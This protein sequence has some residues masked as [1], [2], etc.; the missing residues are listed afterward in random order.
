MALGVYYWF[1]DNN[2]AN[3]LKNTELI[4]Q[5][6]HR[7]LKNLQAQTLTIR[8]KIQ[9]RGWM[10]LANP[11]TNQAYPYYIFLN[12]KPVVWSDYH[13]VPEVDSLGQDFDF[14]YFEN[15]F[16]KFVIAHQSI[17]QEE[18]TLH[19]YVLLPLYKQYRIENQYL[20]SGFNP[21][22][23]HSSL[24]II[25]SQKLKNASE[26]VFPN[27]NFLF[28]FQLTDSQSIT[29]NLHL[30]WCL[31][32]VGL[33]CIAMGWQS[34]IWR[35]S[36][37][38]KQKKWLYLIV[39]T[40]IILL[41]RALT[42][43]FQF[44]YTLWP[45]ELFNPKWYRSF[46]FPSLGDILVN[47][48]II[49]GL[50][51]FF[52]FENPRLRSIKILHQ[53]L[54]RN[55]RWAFGVL[56]ALSFLINFGQY[57]FLSFVFNQAN[58]QLSIGVIDF[59]WFNLTALLIFLL[60]SL[61]YFGLIHWVWRGY[62]FIF[63]RDFQLKNWL[64]SL[65]LV[66]MVLVLAGLG[67]FDYWFLVFFNAFLLLLWYFTQLPRQLFRFNYLSTLYLFSGAMICAIIG[68]LVLNTSQAQ[69]DLVAKRRFANSI[70]PDNDEIAEKFL[71]S[72][73]SNIKKDTLL[74]Q[75]IS[76]QSIDYQ[77]I[78][79]KIKKQYLGSYFNKYEVQILIFEPNR[80]RVLDPNEYS[81]GTFDFYRDNYQ[82]IFYETGLDNIWFVDKPG[83]NFIKRYLVF[84]TFGDVNNP[85]AYLV[86]DLKQ[87]KADPSYVYPELL[88][89]KSYQVFGEHPNY[90]YAIYEDSSLIQSVGDF[91]YEKN[92]KYKWFE[93]EAIIIKGI[94][95]LGYQHLAIQ[96]GF[97]KRVVV[98]SPQS[99][100][101][102]VYSNFAFLFL[103]LVGLIISWVLAYTLQ[104]R[105][106]GA[107]L[108]FSARIQLY[109]TFAFIL[110]LLT[111][112]ITTLSILSSGYRQDFYTNFIQKTEGIA[113]NLATTLVS[114][115][116]NKISKEQL[117]QNLAQLSQ[118]AGLDINL[119]D[120]EGR[121]IQ[122]SQP[123][124][125]D[126]GILSP[127]LNQQA[128]LMLK[129][130]KSNWALLKES[131]GE[132]SY[133]SVYVPIK[134]YNQE[135][136]KLSGIVSIPFFDS[137]S[138][139]NQKL[140]EVISTII[141]IFAAIFIVIL[142]LSYLA[143]QI[144]TIP[145]RLITQKIRL[146]ASSDNLEP[147]EWNS[148]D[149]LGLFVNE[150]NK[151]LQKLDKSRDELAR[152]QKESAWREIAQQVAHEIKN[153]LTPIKLTLQMMQVRL[154]NQSEAVRLMFE[155][156]LDTLLNQVEI[157]SDIASS[158]STFAKMPLPIS[159]RFEITS[160]LKDSQNLYI[161]EKIEL[162]VNIA[163]GKF[164]VRGDKKLIGRI[165]TNLIKNAIE[166]VE[167]GEMPKITIN[168]TN[169]VEGLIQ[170]EFKDNGI[171][172][173]KELNEKIFMPNFTTKSTGSGIGL[174][175]SKRGIEHAGGRI[176]Y[177]S[178]ESLG[179]SFFIELPLVE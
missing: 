61:I 63:P 121:L 102:D 112:S 74:I 46:W 141:N 75:K 29:S 30:F 104:Q 82:K 97:K 33:G 151:M 48:L 122:S 38:F 175:V 171:G 138:E 16:G 118:Y 69:K 131:V 87:K 13:W 22:I 158:F 127:Y 100:W 108:S 58:L 162:S 60:S 77:A 179:T 176:W 168:L 26:I 52:V 99:G 89:D 106:Q 6:I 113:R 174:A 90:S 146:A 110:P 20:K 49:I 8:Q 98:S 15:R 4:K 11:Q 144:L 9:N 28:S 132:L 34:L 95:Q 25:K 170:I 135:R 65:V 177:E 64:I 153:P 178:E 56:I 157:L 79:D 50:G 101:Q 117:S 68:T 126:Y 57:Y 84:F 51:L 105:W 163:Q 130:Q 40:L 78:K 111:V 107:Q 5:K 92:F 125:Y 147:L 32:W 37:F 62:L 53:V 169:E 54:K 119:F 72:T 164:Y 150:Y 14:Q 160:V 152:S 140:R 23:F 85:S 76:S 19:L 35:K 31:V 165:F 45:S 47:L 114:Y 7:E 44:P 88:V 116:E 55:P 109:L 143:A 24:P 81:E 145:L 67:G 59:Q 149:E 96:G 139:L 136:V 39:S 155:R 3:L 10:S 71:Q 148:K 12:Q 123:E 159:E 66:L 115:R 120:E 42:L 43:Y 161:N 128:L 124:I 80:K 137:Q 173:P 129:N 2:S 166:A 18:D 133:Q 91:N 17:P 134:Y 103:L 167:E 86:L 36:L 27:N 83:V 70:L 1:Q 41:I 142:L 73:V 93:N 21:Y 154:Q 94:K 172:I 156:S